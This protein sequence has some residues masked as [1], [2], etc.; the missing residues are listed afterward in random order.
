[1]LMR[2]L[3]PNLSSSLVPDSFFFC[4]GVFCPPVWVN[5]RNLFQ[6]IKHSSRQLFSCQQRACPRAFVYSPKGR[7]HVGPRFQKRT[8]QTQ[9]TQSPKIAPRFNWSVHGVLFRSSFS[10]HSVSSQFYVWATFTNVDCCRFSSPVFP[11][12]MRHPMTPL[13]LPRVSP[14]L[15]LSPP[16]LSS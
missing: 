9:S 7:R 4:Y 8:Q 1:M 10:F 3:P 14:S 13:F 2:K 5:G 6:L 11:L 12:R 16:P 15:S